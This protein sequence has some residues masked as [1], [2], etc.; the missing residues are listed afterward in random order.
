LEIIAQVLVA[1]PG[2]RLTDLASELADERARLA[3][4]AGGRLAAVRAAFDLSYRR[5]PPAPAR[6]FRMLA[7]NPDPDIAT[8]TAAALAAKPAEQVRSLLAVLGQTHLVK[9]QPVGGNRWQ[10]HDLIRL[11]A[12]DLNEHDADKNRAKAAL[13]RLFRHYVTSTQVA[14]SHEGNAMNHLGPRP[15]RGAPP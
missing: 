15:S 13:E 4:H 5:L 6:L 10:M 11:Y 12:A 1:D 3:A 2:L 8:T 9:E 14:V 7:I